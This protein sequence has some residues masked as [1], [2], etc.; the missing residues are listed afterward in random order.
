MAEIKSQVEKYEHWEDLVK[1]TVAAEAKA[2]LR[3]VLY[4]RKMD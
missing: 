2:A 1:K 3:L 4:I